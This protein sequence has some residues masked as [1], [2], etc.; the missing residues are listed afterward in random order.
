[1]TAEPPEPTTAS[2]YPYVLAITPE[3]L[4]EIFPNLLDHLLDKDPGDA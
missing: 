2:Y 3:L 1:M 4:D